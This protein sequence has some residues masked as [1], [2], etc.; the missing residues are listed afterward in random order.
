MIP[1]TLD[2]LLYLKEM[3]KENR[4]VSKADFNERF[5]ISTETT[6][7]RNSLQVKLQRM[8]KQ[9]DVIIKRKER[10]QLKEGEKDNGTWAN[11]YLYRIKP[12]FKFE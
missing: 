3:E 12:G 6:T 9:G 11:S 1:G 5:Q 2:I 8:I 10:P 7:E 4:W